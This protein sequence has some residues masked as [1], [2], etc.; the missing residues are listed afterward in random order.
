[1]RS[2]VRRL[3]V[4]VLMTFAVA[5]LQGCGFYYSLKA[6]SRLNEGVRTFN[7]GKYEDARD[8]FKEAVDL[9]PDNV[10][11]RFFYAMALNAEFEK[12]LNSQDVDKSG[13]I[14]LGENAIKAFQDVIA[15]N[16]DFKFVDQATA[17]IAKAY[18][19]L[20]DVYSP[21]REMP[22]VLEMRSKYLE[23]I[24][25][26]ANLPGQTTRVKAQMFYT[27]GDDYWREGHQML[28][29]F[30]KKDAANPAALPTYPDVP[31]A[32]RAKIMAVVAKSKGFMEQSIAADPDYPEPYLGQKL[33]VMDQMNATNDLV[34]K[35]A[36]R[37]EKD[38]WDE[39]YRDKLSAAQAAE[40]AA[41]SAA[42]AEEAPK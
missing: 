39:L 31:E 25:K 36:F 14:S 6:K 2:H 38:K 35:D 37:P 21:E 22:K 7:K 32:E 13:A 30:A 9:D 29:R 10:N 18:K 11:A 27:I 4:V 24:E 1:M 26:R 12:S 41:A 15:M 19:S 23:M 5:G 16:P 3:A 17:L 20:R 42:P 40:A 8:L 34:K 33:L 28:E